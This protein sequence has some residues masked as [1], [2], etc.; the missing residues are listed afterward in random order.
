MRGDNC[1]H[2]KPLS[3][4]P[5]SVPDAAFGKP[6]RMGPVGRGAHHVIRGLE[7]HLFIFNFFFSNEKNKP[8]YFTELWYY[9]INF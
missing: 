4:T 2:R 1:T 7:L 8:V 3:T 9:N 6:L 5:V